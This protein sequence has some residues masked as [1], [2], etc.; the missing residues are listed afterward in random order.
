MA[1]GKVI[2]VANRF[3]RVSYSTSSVFDDF[4]GRDDLPLSSEDVPS[5]SSSCSRQFPFEGNSDD[6][7][8]VANVS[9]STSDTSLGDFL[10]F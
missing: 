5:T 1:L 8:L 3:R 7:G 9:G 2:D 6:R 4:K 10:M